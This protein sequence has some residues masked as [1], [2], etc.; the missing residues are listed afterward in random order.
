MVSVN[1]FRSNL[2]YYVDHAIENH[3]PVQVSR[4]NGEAFVVISAEDYRREQETLEVL[5]NPSLME[6]IHQSLATFD[7]GKG[8]TPTEEQLGLD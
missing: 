8:F 3:E 1:Q 5:A 2:K 4:K 7:A 6:Q